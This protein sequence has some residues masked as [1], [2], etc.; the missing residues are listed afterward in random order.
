MK[1]Q[2][3]RVHLITNAVAADLETAVNAWLA[4]DT[5]REWVSFQYIYDSFGGVYTVMIGYTE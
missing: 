1:L 5:Q 3:V 4:A 2:V